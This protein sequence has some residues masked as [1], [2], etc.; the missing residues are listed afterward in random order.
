MLALFINVNTIT[1][2][3][4]QGESHKTVSKQSWRFRELG[5]RITDLT[6]ILFAFFSYD[7]LPKI[8]SH[9]VIVIIKRVIWQLL[10]KNQRVPRA[11]MNTEN[12]TNYR[13]RQKGISE[14]ICWERYVRHDYHRMFKVAL[15]YSYWP[16]LSVDSSFERLSARVYQMKTIRWVCR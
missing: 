4:L 1:T 7:E 2:T 8:Y 5:W 6:K 3:I 16:F 12:I 9:N 11:H 15:V 14:A 13:I 10:N